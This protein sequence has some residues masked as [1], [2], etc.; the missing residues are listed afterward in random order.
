MLPLSQPTSAIVEQLSAAQREANP[1]EQRK[2]D[3][4]GHVAMCKRIYKEQTCANG[5][6]PFFKI[7]TFGSRPDAYITEE[8]YEEYKDKYPYPTPGSLLISA[9]GS[10]GRVV[11]YT[12]EK[13]Y[14]QDSNIV[15]L[16]HDNRIVDSFLKQILARTKW[17]LEGS[18]IQRLYNK[19]ILEKV[20]P[21][22]SA[23]EQRAI[24]ILFHNLDSLITLHQRKLEL[25]KNIKKSLLERMFV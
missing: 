16:A 15:W 12:G 21:I 4:F 3:D 24:G 23:S 2:L 17:K 11:E 22:P 7:G 25:L 13:A 8:L 18:T 6:V 10:I 19:D 1:W 5:D 20:I 9:A 14:Y